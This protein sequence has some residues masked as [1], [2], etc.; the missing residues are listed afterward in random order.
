MKFKIWH[1]LDEN[2]VTVE[3]IN[4]ALISRQSSKA[5]KMI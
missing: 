2:F 1:N 4:L 3:M 5:F